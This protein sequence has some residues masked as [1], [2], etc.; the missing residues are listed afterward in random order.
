MD[1]LDRTLAMLR[2]IPRYPRRI[3]TGTLQRL[4]QDMGYDISIRTIQRDL[5]RL[6]ASPFFP[7]EADN[8]KPQ[9]WRWLKDAPTIDIPGLDPQTAMVF[10]MVEEH[11]RSV[12]PVTTLNVLKPWFESAS[13]VLQSG[14]MSVTDWP[15]KV[16]VIPRG[17]PLLPPKI[18]PEIQDTVY[19]A[20]LEERQLR[21]TYRSK[22]AGAPREYQLH[23]LAVVQRGALIYLVAATDRHDDPFQML[24]HRMCSAQQLDAPARPLPGFDL[25]QYIAAGGLNYVIGPPIDLVLRLAPT[26]VSAVTDTPL[27]EDQ[28]ITECADGWFEVKARLPNTIEL[29]A[30]IRGFGQHAQLISPCLLEHGEAGA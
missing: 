15:K 9:G 2:L 19:S 26:A 30:W 16:R 22:G 8:S 3:D 17:M 11:L 12:L 4:L 23:P 6:S 1:T 13:K 25:D 10:K 21:V 20:L 27:S 7:L 14:G 29:Q 28:T 18:D 24:L 5:N